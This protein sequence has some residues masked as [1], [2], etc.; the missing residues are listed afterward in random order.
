MTVGDSKVWDFIHEIY[1]RVNEWEEEIVS[2]EMLNSER[3]CKGDLIQ[4]F[5]DV[6]NIKYYCDRIT[7]T[8]LSDPLGKIAKRSFDE[9]SKKESEKPLI[10]PDEDDAD[11]IFESF[12]N[13]DFSDEELKEAGYEE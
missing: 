11:E 3:W 2:E 13:C 4:L 10:H 9:L 12:E 5:E 8:L 1:K 6:A 7:N